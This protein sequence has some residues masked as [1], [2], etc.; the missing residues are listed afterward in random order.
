MQINAT[1]PSLIQNQ[2][3]WYGYGQEL[4]DSFFK[5]FSLFPSTEQTVIQNIIP[6]PTKNEEYGNKHAGLMKVAELL[7]Q[8]P[9]EGV[10]IPLPK[11]LSHESVESFLQKKILLF[12][13]I[14]KN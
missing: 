3:G 9:I 5:A 10:V 2:I 8:D 1:N 12:L 4:V 13:A 11:G 14:G 6:T 7:A